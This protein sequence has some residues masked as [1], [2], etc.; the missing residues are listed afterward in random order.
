MCIWFS[1]SLSNSCLLLEAVRC[2]KC[3]FRFD[4]RE[5][6]YITNLPWIDLRLYCKQYILKQECHISWSWG[7]I[8]GTCSGALQIIV[9]GFACSQ[10]GWQEHLQSKML[11]CFATSSRAVS[12]PHVYTFLFQCIWEHF[13]TKHWLAVT[14]F[15]SFGNLMG[16]WNILGNK[17]Y[18]RFAFHFATCQYILSQME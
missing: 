16:L 17:C 12:L 7:E 6:K 18:A 15:N 5:E 4:G 13:Q 10:N 9:G 8:L 2:Q 11:K 1:L 14:H 3:L